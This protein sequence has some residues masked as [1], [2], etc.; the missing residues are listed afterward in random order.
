[1]RL[2]LV[3]IAIAALALMLQIATAD[4]HLIP[5]KASPSRSALENRE[6]AQHL[7]LHHAAYVC[8]EGRGQHRRWGCW[9]ASHKI[10]ANGQG[11]LRREWRET[12]NRLRPPTNTVVAR[13]IAAAEQIKRESPGSD[14]WPNC[15]DPYDGGGFSWQDTKDCE[16][17]GYSWSEDPP[18][19]FCGPL[20]VDPQWWQHVIRRYGVPC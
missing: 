6:R 19:Y 17:P 11:W 16:S 4:A 3:L 8:R 15:P 12:A 20:Q 2:L 5:Y 10:R 7:N 14:P 1:M 13:M 18:G 9:A